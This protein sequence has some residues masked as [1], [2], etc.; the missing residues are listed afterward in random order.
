MSDYRVGHVAALL[1]DASMASTYKPALL[2]ALVRICRRTETESI[3]LTELGREFAAMYW[4]QTVVY[5]L[6][7][8]ATVSKESEVV[9]RIRE[10]SV[11]C[12]A[13]SFGDVSVDGRAHVESAMAKVL[14]INV[15]GLFHKSKPAE[16]PLLFSWSKGDA[17]VTLSS[18]SVKFLREHGQVLE[19]LANYHWADYLESCNRLAPRVIQK[20]ARD[21]AKRASLTKYLAILLDDGPSPVV[22]HVIPWSFLLEDPLWDLVPA[23]APCNGAKSDWLPEAHYIDRLMARNTNTLRERVGSGVSLLAGAGDVARL[24]D[25]AISVEWPR[26]WMP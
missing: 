22:D 18:A 17:A 23:C 7:Q 11:A 21:G 4:N 25:A 2:K 20:V 13:R 9:R 5:H 26:F 16:M 15:L 1:R 19:V 6:R 3:P 10:M 12:S 8:A 14:T 24:Y